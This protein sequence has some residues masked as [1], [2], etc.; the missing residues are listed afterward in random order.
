[1]SRGPK[2]LFA[3]EDMQIANM[4]MKSCSTLLII[5]E[6]KIKTTMKYLITPVRMTSIRKPTNVINAVEV[7]GKES[8]LTLLVGM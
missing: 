1:M 8:P 5:K 7:V 6:L 2:E 4:H 3:K